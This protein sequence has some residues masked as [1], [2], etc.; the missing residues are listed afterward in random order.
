[1]R[2]SASITKTRTAAQPV[3]NDSLTF[4]VVYQKVLRTYY[5][6]YPAMNSIFPL[7]DEARVAQECRRASCSATDPASWMS[8]L[9]MPRTRDMSASR[10][11]LLQA[12]CRKVLAA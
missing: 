8:K 2:T 6:L 7:N 3:G 5:L 10:R 4:E 11:T 1:M 9:Y 12:W